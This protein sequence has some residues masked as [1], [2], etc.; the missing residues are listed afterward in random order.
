MESQI[1]A[2]QAMAESGSFELFAKLV[3]ITINVLPEV[4]I[5]FGGAMI[6]SIAVFRK[7]IISKQDVAEEK[8]KI[9]KVDLPKYVRKNPSNV[10]E[11]KDSVTSSRRVIN[12]YSSNIGNNSSLSPFTE[13]SNKFLSPIKE[14]N[15]DLLPF[16]KEVYKLMLD[17]YIDHLYSSGIAG[18]TRLREGGLDWLVYNNRIP[19]LFE[20]LDIYQEFMSKM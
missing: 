5:I 6:I 16:P 4:G 13:E 19:T 2:Q 1:Q 18:D 9:D 14:I 20:A 11:S 3:E 8:K 7:G 12:N 10:T 15:Y 17:H